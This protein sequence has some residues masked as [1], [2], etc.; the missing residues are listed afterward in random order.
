MP[1]P[2]ADR[3]VRKARQ[4]ERLSKSDSLLDTYPNDSELS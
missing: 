1:E 2:R 3:P 4:C